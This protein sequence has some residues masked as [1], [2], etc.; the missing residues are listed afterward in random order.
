MITG[1][2]FQRHS[3]KLTFKLKFKLVR[4]RLFT[5]DIF[6]K[7]KR[8]AGSGS[9]EDFSIGAGAGAGAGTFFPEPEPEPEP[10][11]EP[12]KNITAPHPCEN[13]CP[14]FEILISKIYWF[15][16]SVPSLS[17]TISSTALFRQSLSL[18][19]TCKPPEFNRYGIHMTICLIRRVR[20]APIGT[21]RVESLY[22][23]PISVRSG[24][25]GAY[26]RARWSLTPHRDPS[27]HQNKALALEA[28]LGLYLRHLRLL[29]RLALCYDQTVHPQKRLVLRRSLDAVMGRLV[30]LKVG[31]G[32]GGLWV[33]WEIRARAAEALDCGSGE[34]GG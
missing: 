8:I 11:L 26:M 13:I 31:G 28:V 14:I 12:T 15:N 9:Y 29:G 2:K 22:R 6:E 24:S 23:D 7:K 20:F 4:G 1:D 18:L 32:G 21:E 27:P 17:S 16:Y 5:F 25:A 34:T 33:L 10:E 3:F 19:H 30:E